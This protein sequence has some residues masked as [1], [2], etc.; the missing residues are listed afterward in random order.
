MSEIIENKAVRGSIAKIILTALLDGDKYG[1]EI[2]KEIERLSNGNLV[3]KQPSLYSCLRRMEENDL[4]SSYWQDSTIGGKRHY[5]SLTSKGKEIANGTSNDDKMDELIK[6]LPLNDIEFAEKNSNELPTNSQISIASQEN[7]FNL[8]PK[9]D[10]KYIDESNKES[11]NNSFV[12]YDLF[13]QNIKFIKDS[14]NNTN[15]VEV[16]KNKYVNMD[17]HGQDIEPIKKLEEK[18]SDT[19]VD[20]NQ[21]FSLNEIND[22]DNETTLKDDIFN[23]NTNNANDV[24]LENLITRTSLF[25]T[26]TSENEDNKDIENENENMICKSF[27]DNNEEPFNSPSFISS[28]NTNNFKSIFENDKTNNETKNLSNQANEKDNLYNDLTNNEQ[29]DWTNNLYE[30]NEDTDSSNKSNDYKM[31]IGQLYNSSKLADPYE[32]NKFFVFKEIFP[33]AKV[34]EKKDLHQN[35]S[36]FTELITENTNT[37]KQKNIKI[38]QEQFSLQGLK[39]KI[40]DNTQNKSNKKAYVD[41]NR[42]NMH[43]S[44]IISLIMIIEI[45]CSY[46]FLKKSN[47][48]V[49]GQNFIYFLSISLALAIAIIPSI[50]NIFNRFKLIEIYPNF[51]QNIT[52]M[53]II[54]IFMCIVI[55][56]ICLI[57]GMES[58]SQKDFLSYWIIPIL[59]SSNIVLYTVFYQFLYKTKKYNN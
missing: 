42:L 5:Y 21:N 9:T 33:S 47:N 49:E 12:Q 38:V 25:N 22:I 44:W 30:D 27:F 57:C 24:K 1:Y 14:S 17:N 50:E 51:K 43:T 48:I 15:K 58:L 6:Y 39:L 3:L 54:F 23:K 16:Y 8:T 45:I 40:H 34:E 19:N 31:I 52:K 46:I 55:F 10:I 11:E 26:S 32:E 36:E 35:K 53:I 28:E 13:N 2:C 18:D 4:I 41:I 56:A 29:I 37:T 59:M 20:L 7:L